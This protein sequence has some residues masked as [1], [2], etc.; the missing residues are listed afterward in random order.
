MQG[1]A[2][3][4]R[5]RGMDDYL[6]KPLRMVELGTMLQKWLPLASQ[7]GLNRPPK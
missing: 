1:E 6:S 2:E 3:R 7:S 5:A 4:C